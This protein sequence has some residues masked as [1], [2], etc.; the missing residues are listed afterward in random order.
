M[1]ADLLIV[2]ICDFLDDGDGHYRL[3]EPSRQLG[4]LPGVVVIDC[5]F[6]HHAVSELVDLADVL[7]LPFVHNHDFF[8]RI[9]GRRRRGQV[10]VFEANDY[11]Y[12]V[13]PWSPIA[14]SWQ[15]RSIQEEYRHYMEVADAVQ[16]SSDELA[17]EWSAWARRVAVFRNHLAEIPPLRPSPVRPLTIGWGGSPGHFADWYALA[18]YLERWLLA[19]PD[20]HLAVM[21]NEFARPFIHLPAERYHFTP[22]GT[23]ANY[24]EFLPR[25]DIGLAP[26]L[27]SDYNRCR[28]DVKYL[29]Y[30]AHGVAGIYA[31]AAPYRQSVVPEQTGLLYRTPEDLLAALDH[32]VAE[33]TLRQ[34][35]RAEA[36]AYV[37]RERRLSDR[38]GE[39]LQ[40]YRELLGSKPTGVAL[41]TNLIAGAHREGNYLQLR[42]GLPEQTLLRVLQTAPSRDSVQALQQLV[43]RHP[44][45]AAAVAHLGRSL[46]DLKDYRAAQPWLERARTLQPWSAQVLSELGRGRFVQGDRTGALAYLRE[47][48]TLNPWFLPGWQYLLRL[49]ELQPGPE[50]PESAQAARKQFPRNYQLALAAV[51]V[52]PVGQRLAALTATLDEFKETFSPEERPQAAAAFSQAIAGLGELLFAPGGIDLVTAATAVFPTSARLADLLGHLLYRAGRFE[53]STRAHARALDLRRTADLFRAEFPKEDGSVHYWQFADHLR[54]WQEM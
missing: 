10:T 41:P 2:Q 9:V 54:R 39:R 8:P 28:S 34:R 51:K 26:L 19:H 13:Q 1:H 17:R 21:T 4:R 49:L 50:G 35:L 53:E 32:L 48:L 30:A 47:A 46:N 38:I 6:Y 15:D 3:H 5:H 29:E 27:P 33:P 37:T 22:F 31:D 44:S 43:E 14:A 45:Y 36:H 52:L 24:L 7:I 16:T 42:P 23:L 18:P 20:V 11:F 40:F 12:D 25:L